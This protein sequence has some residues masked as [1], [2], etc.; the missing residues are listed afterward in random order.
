MPA[1]PQTPF[2]DFL[3]ALLR[4]RGLTVRGFA[5]SVGLPVS[6]V[7]TAKRLT[8]SEER[9]PIWADALDLRGDERTRFLDL[10]CLAHAPRYLHGRFEQLR[11]VA[12]KRTRGR[13]S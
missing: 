7:S 2:G 11:L 1:H 3:D 10:A 6:S 4:K 13:K 8:L 5:R 9:M 12:E